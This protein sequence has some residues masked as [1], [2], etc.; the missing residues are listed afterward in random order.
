[1]GRRLVEVHDLA[2]S[3]KPSELHLATRSACLSHDGESRSLRLD[4]SCV[5]GHSIARRTQRMRGVFGG[6]G[7]SSWV[8][9][10][11][12]FGLSGCGGKTGDGDAGAANGA[13]GADAA[14]Q[15]SGPTCQIGASFECGTD[16][17]CYEPGACGL[18]ASPVDHG[19]LG[20]QCLGVSPNCHGSCPTC[21]CAFPGYPT[22]PNNDGLC[23][24]TTKNGHVYVMCP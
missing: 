2:V 5:G 8:V 9:A 18:Y 3:Q 10:A 24:C 11:V 1:M 23:Y 15:S 12:V 20:A 6:R 22:A 19:M 7:Y 16:D 14:S 21:A 4:G 13:D 17:L